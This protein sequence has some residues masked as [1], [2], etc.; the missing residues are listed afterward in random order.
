MALGSGLWAQ[1]FILWA[2]RIRAWMSLRGYYSAYDNVI[3]RF[4]FIFFTNLHLAVILQILSSST[5][6]SQVMNYL[7][8]NTQSVPEELTIL[9]N[10]TVYHF[11]VNANMPSDFSWM[12]KNTLPFLY[13][14]HI[15]ICS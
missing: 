1:G 8:R 3:I 13:I 4:S 12:E 9:R 2:L 6:P 15:F 11:M 5:S 14:D 7:Y 10:F